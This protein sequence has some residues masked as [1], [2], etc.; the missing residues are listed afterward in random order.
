VPDQTYTIRGIIHCPSCGSCNLETK[1]A[2]IVC[3]SKGRLEQDFDCL[4][5][6]SMWFCQWNDTYTLTA[7]A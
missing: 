7:R 1:Y 2:S 3:D 4:Q 6:G 5:C